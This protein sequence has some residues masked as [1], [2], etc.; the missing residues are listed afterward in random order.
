MLYF[1]VSTQCWNASK[2]ASS[3]KHTTSYGIFCLLFEG[4]VFVIYL[5]DSKRNMQRK[6]SSTSC[7]K[8]QQLS[9]PV[10]HP[11]TGTQSVSHIGKDS[12]T[13][14]LLELGLQ[15]RLPNREEKHCKRCQLLSQT[16]TLFL[17][18]SNDTINASSQDSCED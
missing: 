6:R 12:I 17:Q 16:P 5:K 15:L 7:P 9:K 2:M 18:Q 1:L 4:V 13:C 14:S 8:W 10:Q 11:E 3:R